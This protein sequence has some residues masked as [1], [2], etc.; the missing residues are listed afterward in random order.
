MLLLQFDQFL[1]YCYLEQLLV[2]QLMDYSHGQLMNNHC[3][4][5]DMAD[6][7][8]HVIDHNFVDNVQYCNLVDYNHLGDDNLLTMDYNHLEDDILLMRDYNHLVDDNLLMRDY[9]LLMDYIHPIDEFPMD[10]KDSF[11]VVDHKDC[12]ENNFSIFHF[13]FKIGKIL[14]ELEIGYFFFFFEICKIGIFFA[15]KKLDIL[16]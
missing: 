8:N 1:V 10:S 16:I 7:V 15:G 3:A 14:L 5:V 12:L 2:Y 4:V 9:I 6:K 13:L 11:H